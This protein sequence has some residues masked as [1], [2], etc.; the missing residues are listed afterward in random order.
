M[1]NDRCT[2]A[3]I[4]R[5]I[6]LILGILNVIVMAVPGSC[7]WRG[8]EYY[9][10][11]NYFYGVSPIS[12]ALCIAH[13]LA[14]ASVVVSVNAVRKRK[15]YFTLLCSFNCIVLFFIYLSHTV[16]DAL[17]H[18]KFVLWLPYVPPVL[19]ILSIITTVFAQIVAPGQ[20]EDESKD[21]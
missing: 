14:A 1:K 21:I 5:Y 10:Y 7:V 6:I 16:Q 18:D 11:T 9:H 17:L 20:R 15:N 4:A 2:I 13:A 19:A 3:Q 12:P 8:Q